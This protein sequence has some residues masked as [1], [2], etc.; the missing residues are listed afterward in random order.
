MRDAAH[1]VGRRDALMCSSRPSAIR[2]RRIRSVKRRGNR[3]RNSS[4]SRLSAASAAAGGTATAGRRRRPG[5]ITSAGARPNLRRSRRADG[6]GAAGLRRRAGL[7]AARRRDAR[8]D[9][10]VDSGRPVITTKGLVELD[11]RGPG[12]RAHARHSRRPGDDSGRGVRGARPRSPARSTT[13]PSG[14]SASSCNR[15]PVATSNIRSCCIACRPSVGCRTT[16]RCAR[17]TSATRTCCGI[18]AASSRGRKPAYRCRAPDRREIPRG[19]LPCSGSFFGPAS[20]PLE[21]QRRRRARV[22]AERRL[23]VAQGETRVARY[24]GRNAIARNDHREIAHI[25]VVGGE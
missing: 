15:R 17:S 16:R 20:R 1:G 10:V 6:R 23:E 12:A 11:A 2:S 25:G 8:P 24:P 4:R 22:R 3:R 19:R 18:A 9:A 21:T 13:R 5:A 7:H 14:S